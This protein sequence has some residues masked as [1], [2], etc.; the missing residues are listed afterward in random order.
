MNF[1]NQYLLKLTELCSSVK[2]LILNNVHYSVKEEHRNA[3]LKMKEK[4]HKKILLP[5][6][7]RNAETILWTNASKK[8]LRVVILQ[9]KL[10][11]YFASR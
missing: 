11:M 7:D 6:F 2:K 8:G 4:F 10:P 5:Y 3:Y 9:Q 1:L